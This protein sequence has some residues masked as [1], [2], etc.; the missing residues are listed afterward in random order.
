MRMCNNYNLLEHIHDKVMRV[1]SAVESDLAL[2]MMSLE[3]I[4]LIGA[5]F[6]HT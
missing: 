4:C 2:Y 6:F 1:E 5:V 3:F